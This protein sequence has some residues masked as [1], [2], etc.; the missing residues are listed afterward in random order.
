MELLRAKRGYSELRWY[1]SSRDLK[2]DK[3]EHSLALN[4]VFLAVAFAARGGAYQCRQWQTESE[5]KADYDRVE[6]TDAA[7]EREKAAVIPDSQGVIVAGGRSYP[8]LFELD[9]GT[10]PLRRFKNKIKAYVEYYRSG[11]YEKRYNTQSITVLTVVSTQAKSGGEKRM[12]DLLA[13]TEETTDKR[14]F[15]F[16]TLS[17]LTPETIFSAPIWYQVGRKEPKPLIPLA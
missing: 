7:G 14:W 1:S 13:A 5:L 4:E 9:R 16:T 6:I 3:L 15:W 17:K 12:L 11:G 10:M 8:F 2:P